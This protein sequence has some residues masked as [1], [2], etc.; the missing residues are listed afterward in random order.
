ML[1]RTAFK[2]FAL[3]NLSEA[4]F[5][6]LTN[7]YETEKQEPL[8]CSQRLSETIDTEKNRMM[9][10][11]RFLKVVQRY[12]DIRELTP[13]IPHEFVE[14]IVA[15]KRSEPW[16]KKKYTQQIGLQFCR[17]GLRAKKISRRKPEFPTAYLKKSKT[18]LSGRN[19]NRS[20]RFYCIQARHRGRPAL[21]LRGALS[22]AARAVALFPRLASARSTGACRRFA[23]RLWLRRIGRSFRIAPGGYAQPNGAGFTGA[24]RTSSQAKKAKT[25]LITRN[26]SAMWKG[27]CIRNRNRFPKKLMSAA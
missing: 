10:V 18:S 22:Q 16:K 8:D 19:R 20:L 25:T 27:V 6:A 11:D 5:K 13:K 15:H 23:V 7:G 14:K 1:F 12:T 17:A 3:A 26:T 9:N 21:R 4:Q 2:Q 24:L